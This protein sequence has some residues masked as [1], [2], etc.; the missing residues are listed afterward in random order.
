MTAR[1][2]GER[3]EPQAH[4]GERR[5]PPT[6]DPRNWQEDFPHENG[7]YIGRC[8]YCDRHYWGHKRRVVCKLCSTG[9]NAHD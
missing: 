8:M 1:A 5:L 7:R 6:D 4:E 9:T 3:P 2:G